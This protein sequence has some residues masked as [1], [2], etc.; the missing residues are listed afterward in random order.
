MGSGFP[1]K[2]N[3]E[4]FKYDFPTQNVLLFAAGSGIAP[5]R[6]AIESGQLGIAT[7]GTG[8]RTARLYY[9]VRSID[10]VPYVVSFFC[11]F[12]INEISVN[13]LSIHDPSNIFVLIL[14]P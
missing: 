4:G 12:F 9:G 8:G 10:D 3:I 1:M 5:I 6:S 14:I 2:E 7:G 11:Y 13:Y